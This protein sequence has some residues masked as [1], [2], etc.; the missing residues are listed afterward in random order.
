MI[1][2]STDQ[3]GATAASFLNDVFTTK[4]GVPIQG[5]I[6]DFLAFDTSSMGVRRAL[7]SN[8]QPAD[9]AYF[10]G[11]RFALGDNASSGYFE[12]LTTDL[13]NP[14][15]GQ[16][17]DPTTVNGV[18]APGIYRTLAFDP[19]DPTHTTKITELLGI[20]R[21]FDDPAHPT[22]SMVSNTG[23]FE[24]LLMPKSSDDDSLQIILASM[25]GSKA[26]NLY[27]GD[28]HL[29]SG[30][31]VAFPLAN[32][33]NGS[34]AGAIQGSLSGF[35]DASAS[36]V[37]IGTPSDGSKVHYG[38]YNITSTLPAGFSRSGRFIV[39]RK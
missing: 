27:W 4:N 9:R 3:S 14:D 17:T 20:F 18:P 32:I 25:N 29:G 24:V 12:M 31:F 22:S 37:T 39:F 35:L 19:T 16:Y 8:G 23:S 5:F 26:T 11:D 34:S 33:S 6:S 15:P 38:R 7:M 2:I 10:S 21:L 13:A 28:A 36:P 1:D 30:S